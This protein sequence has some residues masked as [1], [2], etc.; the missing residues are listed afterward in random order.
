[1]R[2]LLRIALDLDGVVYKF[3]DTYVYMM[4]AYRGLS[5]PKP[6][7]FWYEWD[8]P[9]AYT[10]QNDRDWMWDE[11]VRLGLFR[12][13]HLYKG[14]IEGVNALAEV[15]EVHVVTSRPKNAVEDTLAFLAYN[16]LPLAGVNILSEKQPKSSVRPEF[17][18]YI[19]DGPHNIEDLLAN[20]DGDVIIMDRPW[21]RAEAR[22][23]AFRAYNWQ[24]LVS[25]VDVLVNAEVTA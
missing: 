11:G 14:A 9:D 19:D 25:I 7:L 16:R 3:V 6:E 23:E 18:I 10:S 4:N 24:D 8:A 22:P 21:N 12:Y 2:Q 1:M 5:I 17:D 20:T 15:A 13:G